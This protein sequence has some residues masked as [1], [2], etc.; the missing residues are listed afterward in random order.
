MAD[1]AEPLPCIRGGLDGELLF[2]S[3]LRGWEIARKLRL[4]CD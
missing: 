1:K 3:L 4:T 2:V